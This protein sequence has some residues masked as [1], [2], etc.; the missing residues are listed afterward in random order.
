MSRHHKRMTLGALNDTWD[1]IFK[2]A[3]KQ[4]QRI[5]QA[6]NEAINSAVRTARG[7]IERAKAETN[8]RL[9]KEI[10]DLERRTNSR[11]AD[12]DRRHSKNLQHATDIIYDDMQR[13]FENMSRA[14]EAEAEHL[15]GRIDNVK[16]WT[17]RNLDI[18]DR[19]IRQ[20]QQETNRR[21]EQQQQQIASLQTSVQDIFDRFKSE[22]TMARDV[23]NE[24][25]ELLKVIRENH[26]ID[27]YTPGE[28]REIHSHINDMMTRGNDPAASIIAESRII[29]RDILKMKEKALLEKAK[30]DEILFQTR[31]RLAAILD[32]IGKSINQTIERDGYDPSSIATDFWTDGEYTK[33]M[34]QLRAIENQL[35]NEESK[36]KMSTE[37]IAEILREIESLNLKGIELMQR[38]LNRTLQS[39]DRAE[40]TLDIVN[41]MIRQGYEIK[42]EN[43]DDAFDY[44]GGR[45]ES[46]Q[47]E[48]VFAILRHPNTGEEVTVVLQPN[49]DDKTNSI[50]IHVDNPNQPI[51]E[52]Q[53]RQSIERVRQEMRKSGYEPGPIEIPADG[54]DNIIPQMQS[55]RQMRKA[56]AASQLRE[57]L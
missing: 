12:L 5:E 49:A 45:I 10:G 26:P 52:Q 17:Q 48:G 36:D 2:Q 37:Q 46:D 54:G 43:G 9:A 21:F 33:V 50:D 4:E 8:R 15:N 24:M 14:I 11:L 23:V 28:L 53:L 47:R 18:I 57:S 6:R 40:I 51:T 34:N 1:E 44:L 27:V 55:G 41:A 56:G 16:Q 3:R 22:A 42:I 32:V 39:Q 25:T 7:E 29:I 31:T 35:A 19:N 30:H 38:A 13:G 20:M